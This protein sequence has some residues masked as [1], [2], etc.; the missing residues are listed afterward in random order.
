MLTT[1]LIAVAC[2]SNTQTN[3]TE[4][5]QDILHNTLNI[6]LNNTVS[7][8]GTTDTSVVMNSN[9]Y[10]IVAYFD[11]SGCSPCRLKELFSWNPLI[12]ESQ[13]RGLPVDFIF[14][15]RADT[16]DL[17]ISQN[18]AVTQLRAPVIFD[19]IGLFELSNILPQ[20]SDMHYFLLG[21]TNRVE[22]F[23]NPSC[24][25]EL[26]EQF[27]SRIKFIGEQKIKHRVI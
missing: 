19:P 12:R 23:G 27:K 16:S 24:H 1:A 4:N 14:I 7:R 3:R 9:R 25:P 2:G 11:D 20:Q 17:E 6:P 13:E 18:P 5:P 15:I 26:W 8:F 10:K 21:E 22:M